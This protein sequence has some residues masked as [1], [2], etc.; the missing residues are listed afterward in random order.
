MHYNYVITTNI[1]KRVSK[2]M[3]AF[4]CRNDRNNSELIISIITRTPSSR[5]Y[6]HELHH[7]F[8]VGDVGTAYSSFTD[9]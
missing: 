9:S 7:Q 2:S 1:L 5:T 4:A 6:G 8:R 3:Y